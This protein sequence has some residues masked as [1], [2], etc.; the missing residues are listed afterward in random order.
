MR[1]M[2]RM[3]RNESAV[4]D[5]VR[6]SADTSCATFRGTYFDSTGRFC[7]RT[8]VV[9][10]ERRITHRR[11]QDCPMPWLLGHCAKILASVQY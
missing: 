7:I 2:R 1:E 8:L 6:S 10:N 11:I 9:E 3:R 5:R 4:K